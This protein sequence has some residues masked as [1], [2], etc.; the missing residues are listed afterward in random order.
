[1]RRRRCPRRGCRTVS[2]GR[3][4][5]ARSAAPPSPGRHTRR[6]A[7]RAGGGRRWRSTWLPTPVRP[8]RCPDGRHEAGRAGSATVATGARVRRALAEPARL[9]RAAGRAMMALM[10]AGTRLGVVLA[11]AATAVALGVCAPA[12][13]ANQTATVTS[14]PRVGAIFFPSVLG[15]SVRLGLPH[16]CTGSVVHSPAHDL[17]LTAAHCVAGPGLGY[18]FAP[19]YHD[20]IAPFGVWSVRHAYV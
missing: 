14:I 10:A 7:L 1:S 19:G 13:A 15:S 18:D 4:A 20:G 17:V 8:R 11:A 5:A 16:I 9:S 12:Q 3:C 6:C 2:R